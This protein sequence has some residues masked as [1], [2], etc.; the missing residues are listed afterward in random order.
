[1]KKIML[2]VATFALTA[3]AA[4]NTFHVTFDDAAWI[5]STQVKAGDYKLQVEGDKATLKSGKTVI[6]APAKLETADHKFETTGVVMD[7]KGKVQEIQ[8][9][10]TKDRIVFQTGTPSG[11]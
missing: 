10:G 1:M 9:G 11:F 6:E 5:G 4:S 3:L 7:S 8:I 2:A